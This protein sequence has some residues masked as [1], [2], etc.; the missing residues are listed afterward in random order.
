MTQV[1]R[2]A[3]PLVTQ[4]KVF[5]VILTKKKWFDIKYIFLVF[6]TS[7]KQRPKFEN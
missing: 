3:E 7:I 2:H 4:C 5:S 1:H 6:S